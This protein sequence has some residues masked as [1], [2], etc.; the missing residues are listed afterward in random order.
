V[1]ADKIAIIKFGTVGTEF[2]YLINMHEIDSKDP[3]KGSKK[4]FRR[5]FETLQDTYYRTDA[6]G[7]ITMVSP[8][9]GT[10]MACEP[11]QLLNT[12]IAQYY[13][14]AQ[15]REEFLQELANNHGRV[16]SFSAK[17]RRLDDH[18]IWISTNAQYLLDER[19][20]IIGI[21]GT[22]RDISRQKETEQK[23]KLAKFVMD[24]APLNITL[25]D[26]KARIRYINK[27]GCETLGYTEK[28]LLKMGIPDIDPFFP[29]EVWDQHWK[30]LKNKKMV[31]VETH[32]QR[33]SGDI[34]PIEMLANYIEFENQA[35]NI[36]FGHDITERKQA[37][38]ALQRFRIA[39]DNSSDSIFLIDRDTMMFIDVN[40]VA[41]KQ[42]GYSREEFLSMG[43][44]DIKPY[45]SRKDLKACFDRVINQEAKSGIIDTVHAS[46]DGS[47]FPVE[48]RL[49]PFKENDNQ[50]LVAV[51]RD[52]TER[53]KNEA[54]FHHIIDASPVPY[55]LND[56]EQNITYLNPAFV[57]TFGYN[58]ED[59]P[60]LEHWWPKAYPDE[61]YRQWIATTW[62]K[63]LDKA[64]S[65]GTA[66]EPIELNIRCKD[67]SFRTV[68]AGAA[69]L[70]ESYKGNHLV[71]LYDIT[72]RK[73]AE[74]K[75]RLSEQRF[76]LA[77]NGTNDGLWD[78][79]LETDEVYYS[80][81]WFSMLGYEADVF[82]PVLAT[83]TELVHP[84]DKRWVLQRVTDYLEERT[85]S[86]EVEMRMRHKDGHNVVVL[87]RASKV[88][89]DSDSKPI[90]LVGTHVD[91]TYRNQQETL[92]EAS[93]KKFS[94]LF[95]S[96]SDGLFIL[97][98]QGNF[99]DINQT[100]HERLGYS[101]P[102]ML[103]MKLTELDPPEFAVKV[104]QRLEQI[105]AHGMATFETAHYRKDGSIMPVEVNARIIELDGEEVF[106]SVIRDISERKMFE[107][108][109]RQ[110]QKMEAIGT[111]VGG[112]AHDFNNMLA[113][114]Q[115]NV[116][117][118]KKQMH[119]HPVTAD[120]LAN[121]EQLGKRAADM[122]HQLLTFARKDT[123]E[124]LP[125]N[126]NGFMEEGY[127]LINAAI[128]ENI[129][130]QACICKEPLHIK[131]DA[132]QLQQALM[133]LM[134]NA[135]DAVADVPDPAIRCSLTP[136]ESDESFRQSHPEIQAERFACITVKDNGHGI[137]D[138]QLGKIFEPFF[139]TKGVSEGSGLGL[140]MLYGAVQTHGGVVEVESE[141]DSGTSF[142][143]YFPLCD[144]QLE[145]VAEKQ[146]G[147]TEVHGETILLVDDEPDVRA[148]TSEVLISMGYRVLKAADGEEA[149]EVFKSNREQINIIITD[150]VMPRMGGIDLVNA[151][152]Q[153]NETLPIILIT[154]YD[155]THELDKICQRRNCQVIN[156]PFDYDDL[157]KVVQLTLKSKLE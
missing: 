37:E 120:K 16:H 101:K 28:E 35:Y 82:P 72:D 1:P 55:A 132:T 46:K 119:N 62:Q 64:K 128:P 29:I 5:I 48:I 7:I 77:M 41:C 92:L 47:E 155:N 65:K 125:F 74:E 138:E 88:L 30:D 145:P 76:E 51:A 44:H 89:R 68:I 116:Y 31:S 130:H 152:Y 118:A 40:E 129:D 102:E 156:K 34:F 157:F 107:E 80:P 114:I 45:L 50:L 100:A 23:L 108:Q 2:V 60:T 113:A 133:N 52:I 126:L 105:L 96:S 136:F 94:T 146:S 111:L 151:I 67:G 154:G 141:V 83:W 25:L 147:Q 127:K 33:K 9:A 4:L 75:L 95:D 69:S 11:N 112:I 137:A 142:H 150:V 153:L 87:S 36:A 103:K 131:G 15:R 14:D 20:D 139:T 54:R 109:L 12:P 115:G 43:P 79:N 135:I 38:T 49:K 117:M 78:W 104:P 19:G 3:A 124:L 93:R 98:M 73:Q 56:E 140:S 123:V 97:D 8:S 13:V 134:N 53:Q 90:R 148:T 39:I 26:S 149:L 32:H 81:R 85:D 24:H 144:D 143:V 121:I 86:F 66:F 63:H 22:I 59:I 122:V 21:E 27:T 58:I 57:N 6:A 17:I 71:T 110:S 99:I 42:L 106:F 61:K 84:D 70:T 91:I 10:L 18:I